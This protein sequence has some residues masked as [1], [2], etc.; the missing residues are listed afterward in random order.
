MNTEKRS[1]LSA[2][3]QGGY[4]FVTTPC[5]W[6]SRG[7]PKAKLLGA[8]S[9]DTFFGASKESIN[10]GFKRLSCTPSLRAQR[11]AIKVKTSKPVT[12]AQAGV[13]KSQSTY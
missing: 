10:K 12:P 2:A 8:F 3:R 4:E 9:L 1:R 11:R 7:E 13:Q 5:L 6:F